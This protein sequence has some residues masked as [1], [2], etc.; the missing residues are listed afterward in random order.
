MRAFL[1]LIGGT[2][3]RGDKVKV[4]I[5]EICIP[6]LSVVNVEQIIEGQ[7]L[8]FLVLSVSCV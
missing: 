3:Q 6:A 7:N 2:K 8:Y 4:R 5:D 1:T